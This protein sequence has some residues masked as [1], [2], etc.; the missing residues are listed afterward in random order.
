M[1]RDYFAKYGDLARS[2]ITALLDKYAHDG[3]LDFENP[4]SIRQDPLSKIGTPV[5]I[6]R[7]FGG[8][9]AYDAAILSLAHALYKSA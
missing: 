1:K 4:E 9:P 6:M 5:E 3:G 2:V 8:R 7:A